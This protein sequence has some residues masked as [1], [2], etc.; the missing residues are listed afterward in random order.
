MP[1]T[2]SA[3]SKSNKESEKKLSEHFEDRDGVLV[4]IVPDTL[5]DEE[6]GKTRQLSEVFD[7]EWYICQTSVSL[8]GKF[9]FKDELKVGEGEYGK[10]CSFSLRTKKLKRGVPWTSYFYVKVWGDDLVTLLQQL[11]NETFIKVVGDLEVYRNTT[12]IRAK[13]IIPLLN[14]RQ[15]IEEIKTKEALAMVNK[16]TEQLNEMQLAQKHLRSISDEVQK[17]IQQESGNGTG[18]L[19]R[20]EPDISAYIH[21]SKDEEEEQAMINKQKKKVDTGAVTGHDIEHLLLAMS[22]LENQGLPVED[23]M[24]TIQKTLPVLRRR[25]YTPLSLPSMKQLMAVPCPLIHQALYAPSDLSYTGW[26]SIG[27]ACRTVY[28]PSDGARLFHAISKLDTIR[29]KEQETERI[30]R[31]IEQKGMLPWGCH[32]VME[33]EQCPHKNICHGLLSVL[34]KVHTLK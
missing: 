33:G 26:L 1:D 11:K 5:H 9:Y 13:T 21:G 12:Y 2:Y 14:A 18:I 29:Y 4:P 22:G 17:T 28:A 15:M 31:Y 25:K 10:Y 23:T 30:W 32:K 7:P 3:E 19:Q 27:G 24:S 34:R 8:I 16:D 20:E 6:N